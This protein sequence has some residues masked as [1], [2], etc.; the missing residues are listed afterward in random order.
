MEITLNGQG[1]VDSIHFSNQTKQL[2]SLINFEGFCKKLKSESDLFRPYK[3]V[4]LF[5]L[6]YIRS[7]KDSL[8]E[9]TA[10]L[11][12][13]SKTLISDPRDSKNPVL[14]LPVIDM[15]IMGDF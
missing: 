12:K 7:G 10:D 4:T 5:A 13:S 15:V 2:D 8:I 3:D 14:L 11:G 9:N 6:I 1:N